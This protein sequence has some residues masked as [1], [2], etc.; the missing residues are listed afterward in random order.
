MEAG[1]I[2]V[3]GRPRARLPIGRM[4]QG[5]SPFPYLLIYPQD[6]HEPMLIA[7]LAEAGVAGGLEHVARRASRRT[8]TGRHGHPGPRRA[9]R[10][11]PDG[12]AGGGG[13]RP[14][15]GCARAW[16]SASRAA[17]PKGS[18]MWRTSRRST[19]GTRP[20]WASGASRFAILF[21]L[22]SGRARLIGM[23]PPGSEADGRI[24]YEDVAPDARRLTGA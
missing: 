12:L 5:V 9:A 18:S 15:H 3:E 23:V 10:G 2:R 16:A 13:W 14:Q 20:S 24:D 7:A 1:E 22:P 4:G 8:P 21:P 17:R 6:V 11:D 19:W